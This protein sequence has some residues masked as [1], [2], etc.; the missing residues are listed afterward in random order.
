VE[1]PDPVRLCELKDYEYERGLVVSNTLDFL[2]GVGGGNLL[3][4]G[5]RGTGKS[6]TIKA[7]VNEFCG[8]GL[9]IV[10]ATKENLRELPLLLDTLRENPLKFLIFL[11]DLSFSADDDAFSAL[12]SMLE[13]GLVDQ[14]FNCLL[15]AT[16][17]RRHLVKESFSERDADDVHAGDTMQEKLSLSDRCARTVD[18]FAPDQRTYCH[19]VSELARDRQLTIPP[20]ELERGAIQWALRSGG[21]SPR[22]A[23]QFVA[24]A[25]ARWKKGLPVS[26]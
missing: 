22:A 19:I 17:N 7:V 1:H 9:R 2:E 4:Y 23:K 12:K 10:E 15:Y 5:D 24:G 13:G 25:E 21:R 16:S 18:F 20:A 6:S 14:P 11:D 8:R 26:D 3:L